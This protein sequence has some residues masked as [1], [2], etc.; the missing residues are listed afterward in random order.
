MQ[1]H[2]RFVRSL[3]GIV[4]SV[5]M[6]A[7]LSAFAATAVQSTL[8]QLSAAKPAVLVGTCEALIPRLSVLPNTNITSVKSVAAE[9][10]KVGGNAVAEHCLVTGS[11]YDRTGEPAGTTYAIGFEMRLPQN[12]NGRFWYQGNGGIDGSVKTALGDLG[13]GPVTCALL[14]GF[15]VISSDA[16]HDNRKTR[17]PGFGLDPQARLDYGYQAVGKLSL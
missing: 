7:A 10:I 3:R 5:I 1:T 9:E 16:G 15:A 8:P 17:G 14:Q 12:W 13:G 4:L 11:M 6:I 2:L